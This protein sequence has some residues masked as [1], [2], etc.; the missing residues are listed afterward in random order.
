MNGSRVRVSLQK[1]AR[2]AKTRI[3]TGPE[4]RNTMKLPEKRGVSFGG[5]PGFKNYCVG[6]DGSVWTLF[7][8]GART[9]GP[10]IGPWREIRGYVNEDGYEASRRAMVKLNAAG[11]GFKGGRPR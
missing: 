8:Q 6:S 2:G 9:S 5:V 1:C 11:K 10:R 4:H 7:T 3:G